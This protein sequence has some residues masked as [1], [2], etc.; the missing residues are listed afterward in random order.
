MKFRLL[1]ICV[2]FLSVVAGAQVPQFSS[3]N[4]A[5]WIYNNPNTEL[6]TTNILANKIYLYTN[7]Q[8]LTYTLT[9]PEFACSSGQI[10]N[11]RVT[12]I[13]DQWQST[14]FVK[15]KVAL[16]AA[17]LDQNGMAVDSVTYTP[18]NVS[19]TNYV[20][21][22]INVPH[23]LSSARLRFASWLADVN[24]NGAVRQ[25][26]MTASLRGDVNLDGEV[27]LADVNA[28]IDVIQ[29]NAADEGLVRRADVNQDGEVG[30]ADVNDVIDLILG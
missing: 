3:K 15:D 17:I 2:L 8:G 4:Y 22:S 13:T 27:T 26:E 12:W 25:I 7:S 20:N 16:T 23:G 5:G 6:N 21:L 9:S 24:S 1:F 30:L 29:G 19:R 11:M 14:G 10:I 28:V 18:T